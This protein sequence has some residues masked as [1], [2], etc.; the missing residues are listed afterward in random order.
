MISK[1]EN[2]I[3]IIKFDNPEYMMTG[4]PCYSLGYTG[5]D[6]EGYESGGH[7]CPVGTKWSDIWGTGWVKEHAEVMG[8]PKYNPL[9]DINSLKGYIFPDPD[10]ERICGRIYEMKKGYKGGDCFLGGSHRDTL[11][12]KSYMLAGMENMMTFLYDEPGYA[13]ELLHRIMDF[14]IGIANHYIKLGVETVFMS[15]DLG[16]QNSLLIG[17]DLL[18]EFFVPEY[19]RLFELYKKH[20]VIINFHSCGHIEPVLDMFIDLG[21]DVLNPVQATANDLV[22]VRKITENKIALQGGISTDIIMKGP[23]GVIESEVERTIR[24]LGKNGGYF[25][26]PDQGMP[27][28]KEH[29]DALWRA[30]ENFTYAGLF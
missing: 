17:A 30:A 6:H 23:A 7:D 22:K 27:F 20:G 19:R 3:R 26:G 2:A 11:W 9:S 16:M 15:D 13:R 10:D 25:C 14:Q 18:Y 24:L 5:C 12:E 8:F 29:I 28:P 1:K 21:V 4:L